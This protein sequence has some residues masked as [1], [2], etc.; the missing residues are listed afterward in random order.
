MSQQY[1]PFQDRLKSSKVATQRIQ[2]D[3]LFI[4]WGSNY[5]WLIFGQQL[6]KR[7]SRRKKKAMKD[8]DILTAKFARRGLALRS[9]ML[10]RTA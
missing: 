7:M 3:Y 8:T 1:L 9:L 10:S 4:Y 5:D 6:Q 2:E